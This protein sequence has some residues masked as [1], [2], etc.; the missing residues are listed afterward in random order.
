MVALVLS[1]LY[2]FKAPLTLH[3]A[4]AY[5][6]DKNIS[7]ASIKGNFWHTLEI[8]TIAL[9]GEPVIS[10]I[11][12]QWSVWELLNQTIAI[13]SCVIKDVDINQTLAFSRLLGEDNTTQSTPSTWKIAIE[14]LQLNASYGAYRIELEAKLREGRADIKSTIDTPYLQNIILQSRIDIQTLHYNG[15][16]THQEEA[17]EDYGEILDNL[18]V[19]FK[20]D[21]QGVVVELQ[22]KALVGSFVTHDFNRSILTLYSKE[23]LKPKALL[24]ASLQ[25][26]EADFVLTSNFALDGIRPIYSYLSIDSNAVSLQLDGTYDGAMGLKGWLSFPK[27]S[28]LHRFDNRLHLDKL[29][30]IEL[31]AQMDINQTLTVALKSKRIQANLAYLSKTI[32]AHLKVASQSVRLKGNPNQKLNADINITSLSQLLKT[33]KPIYDLE[34]PRLK[35]DMFANM[36]LTN[37]KNITLRLRSNALSIEKNSISDI[38]LKAKGNT[39]SLTIQSYQLTAQ[40]MKF[41]ATKPSTL[42]YKDGVLRVDKFWLNDA[43]WVEGNYKQSKGAFRIVGEGL[44]LKHPDYIDTTIQSDA[45]VLVNGDSIDIKGGIKLDGGSILYKM[46]QNENFALDKDIVFLHK[47]Q[48]KAPDNLRIDL[49]IET[50]APLIYKTNEMSIQAHSHLKLTKEKAKDIRLKGSIKLIDWS[51]Y[52]VLQN[53]IIRLSK[54]AIH[55]KG[56]PAEPILDIKAHYNSNDAKI[57]ILVVGTPTEPILNFS[58]TP[59]M[60][61]EEILSVL[62]LDTSQGARLNKTEDL[63]YLLGGA[64]AKS[65]LANMGLRVEHFVISDSTFEVGKK[66]GDKITIIYLGD[67]VSSVKILYEHSKNIEADFI[68]NKESSSMDIFYKGEM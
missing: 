29:G 62:L 67:E 12:C 53:K 49:A 22:S 51:S 10:R 5:L 33:L 42:H 25:T 44:K 64:L 14:K 48:K 3:F 36:T 34:T 31:Q 20:G 28:M 7:I 50:L 35:G 68:I 43:L 32:D 16:I 52:Y 61:K 38:Q 23:R 47:S 59:L 45:V 9:K 17:F 63:Q 65:F 13:D 24:P 57:T 58:S 8:E 60:S 54:S 19:D 11:A 26:L 30:K 37:Q 39:Q 4:N 1:V 6:Q 55:F 27:D 46:Q 18:A 15:T 56:N 66:I 41:F 40:K 2:A 21:K